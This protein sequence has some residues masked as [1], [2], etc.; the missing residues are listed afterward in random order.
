MIEVEM[1]AVRVTVKTREGGI[2]SYPEPLTSTPEEVH[3][4]L[5]NTTVLYLSV[6]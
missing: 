5:N 4:S 3:L 1:L 2:D 6:N